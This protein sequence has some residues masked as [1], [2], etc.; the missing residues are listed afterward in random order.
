MQLAALV[1]Q[2]RAPFAYPVDQQHLRIVLKAAV[3]DLATVACVHG[4]RY[5]WP[6]DTD[7]PKPMERLGDDGVHEYW[8]VTIPSL[9]RRIRYTIYVEGMDGSY[10]WL[11][12]NGPVT[13]RPRGAFFQFPYI[14]RADLFKQP[15]WL[16]TAVFYQIFP[17]RFCNGNPENDPRKHRLKWGEK[18]NRESQAGG[19]LDGIR[20]KLDYVRDLGIGGIYLTPIFKAPTNHKYDT[21]DYYKID[22]AFGTNDEF[23]ALVSDV[24][25][26]GMRFLLDAVFN[27]SG[28]EWFAFKD[29]I[30]KGPESKYADWFYNLYS[31]PVSPEACN[32]ETFANRVVE[33]PKLDTAN[34]DLQKYLLAVATYWIQFA[35]IDG[36]RLDVANEVNHGF[37]RAFRD[38]V[39]AAKPDAWILGEIWH[40]PT[41]WLQ[42]DQYD[43]AMNYPWREAT[44]AFLKGET[45]AVEYDRL[46]TRIRF[47]Q[48]H[49]ILKGQ[50][51]LL[52]SHDT[53]R[54]LTELGGKAKAAQAAVLLM[55]NHGVPL[56]YYGDEIGM[57]GEGDPD[58][59]RCYPWHDETQQDPELL[60]LYKKLIR[61]RHA[62]PWL[63]DG[64]WETFAA[65]PVTGL[66]GYHRLPSAVVTP[67]RPRDEEGLY[68]VINNSGRPV[69]VAIPADAEVVDLLAG[70]MQTGSIRQNI[71]ELPA[72]GIAVLAPAAL[73]ASVEGAS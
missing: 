65:D 12:E 67:D 34:P 6:A 54:V 48:M 7:T 8:G 60:S 33:M 25:A 16:R 27:H 3:G 36:W 13:R 55:T 21:T 73:A 40:D 15:E 38:A 42:G 47:S 39:K 68:V 72:R 66:F 14:H 32:Y 11:T 61:L 59:R 69:T 20:Q 19:D 22:P 56:V 62:F 18:P 43:A 24:H 9:S 31:F 45:D 10:A 49:E 37:W 5:A 51:T 46:L 35:D 52:G 70:E 63:N 23:K 29:V 57:P 28:K 41:E 53:P 58:C 71:L 50:L 64:A 4:D 17:D 26:K 2:S 1:H 30:K 44:L